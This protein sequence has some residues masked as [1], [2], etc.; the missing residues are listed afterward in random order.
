M[1]YQNITTPYI[2][3]YFGGSYLV[4][5][6]LLGVQPVRVLAEAAATLEKIHFI[7]VFRLPTDRQIKKN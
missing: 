6:T 3:V 1:E 5:V 2:L 7:H 4:R